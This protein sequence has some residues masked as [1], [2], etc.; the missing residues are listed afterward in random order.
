M[1]AM[2]MGH[3]LI[4]LVIIVLLFGSKKIPELAQGLGKGIK[5]FKKEMDDIEEDESKKSVAEEKK[6]EATQ[7]KE[8]EKV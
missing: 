2:S 3:W 7:T 4:V 1:G 8:S 5:T 6:V